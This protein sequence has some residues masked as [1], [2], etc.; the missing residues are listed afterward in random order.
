MNSTSR[1]LKIFT[2]FFKRPLVVAICTTIFFLSI[3]LF[4]LWQR[5]QI[6]KESDTREMTNIVNLV[7][8][9]IN[10]SLK[11][12]YSVALSLALLIDD[13]GS[14]N[15]FYEVA[16]SLVDDNP[17]IDGVQMVPGGVIQQVYP[18]EEN[19]S[20]IG[21]DILKDSKIN[22]EAYKAIQLRK[23]YF[24]GPF[25][26]R[27]GGYAILGRLPVFIKNKFWGF[28]A[29]IIK[30]DNLLDKSGIF[31]LVGDKY[32]FQFSKIQKGTGEEI[33][34]SPNKA[35]LDRS[36]SQTVL[37]P[38]GD[39]KFYISP[40]NRKANFYMLLPFLILVILSSL[41]LGWAMFQLLKQP[42]RLQALVNSQAGELIK[43]ELKFRSIYNQ[44]AIGVAL[45]DSR[46]GKILDAN[47]KYRELIGYSKE[48]ILTLDY[49][50]LS[51]PE[52][53]QE[54]M[55]NMERLRAG[56]FKEYTMKKRII[57]K[58]KEVVWIKLTV[59]AMW[60][61]GESPTTH[62]AI[63]EDI[64]EKKQA[65]TDLKRS[66]QTVMDQ[67]RRLLNFSYIVSHNL[68][69]H[70]SNFQSILNLY[71]Y[72][73]SEE[74]KIKYIEMLSNVADSLNQTLVDLNDV[75]SIHSNIDLVIEPVSVL[76]YINR[77]LD[78]LKIEIEK[79]NAVYNVKVPEEMVVDF[80][81]AY[82]E[83]VLL[84]FLSN[85]LRYRNKA[86]PL[87]VTITG[88]KEGAGW[89]LEIADNGIGI[90]LE[91]HRDKLF[92][93]YK[94]FTGRSNSRGVGL[95]ITKNQLDAMDAKI[96]VEST[97][98]KGSNFKVHFK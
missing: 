87:E 42:A 81:A 70:S 39:W 14:V 65:E 73:E 31:P 80:N 6:L 17:F 76:K 5:Y 41:F 97:V 54:D 47:K 16:P 37:L 32:N 52:D 71:E 61:E 23:M 77:T 72:S 35:E 63:V 3:G 38:D 1:L 50:Q 21:Y 20:V 88:R 30:F 40:V 98:G 18:F 91:K 44:A 59:S 74:E 56:V 78:L 2:N 27:Q 22:A 7:E 53:L 36:Y 43:S 13:S 34:Y 75:T 96:N 84:N 92:G 48:E 89:V 26:L 55:Q 60:H 66:Y 69:S 68:R 12:S 57:R 19:R 4:G 8:Q 62:V 24:A 10:H 90:D 86:V 93:L 83:S 58:D 15:N 67:N 51:Y 33:V 64:T 28:S 49:M 85:T 46:T 45:L 9:N 94:T 11:N 29:I 25:E 95:F 79:K 82:M